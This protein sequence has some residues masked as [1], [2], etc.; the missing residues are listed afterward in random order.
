[1]HVETRLNRRGSWLRTTLVWIPCLA[2][3]ALV[4]A[5]GSSLDVPQDGAGGSGGG[6]GGQ[7]LDLFACE[8]QLSCDELCIHISPGDCSS[9]G[10]LGC[11]GELLV[12]GAPGVLFEQDRPGPGGFQA[13]RLLVL[14]GDGTAIAQRRSRSCPDGAVDCDLTK[15][16]WDVAEQQTCT[17]V[18]PIDDGVCVE[19]SPCEASPRFSDCVALEPEATCG[20]V[21]AILAGAGS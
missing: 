9:P 11:A 1:M 3:A 16:A 5:C 2:T 12:S 21:A 17:L 13:D 14:R 8:L 7:T 20:D 10:A 6:Q 18:S 19:G 4:A 15:V